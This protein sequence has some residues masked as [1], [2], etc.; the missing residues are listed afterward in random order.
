M[1]K[2]RRQNLRVCPI[3]GIVKSGTCHV[4]S[5]LSLQ[6]SRSENCTALLAQLSLYSLG[7][8]SI[9]HSRSAAKEALTHSSTVVGAA[10]QMQHRSSPVYGVGSNQK[11]SWGWE[12]LVLA[13]TICPARPW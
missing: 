12:N 9:N 1:D 8:G 10:T 5:S 4:T 6:H 11:S 7:L 13:D 2:S 3:A